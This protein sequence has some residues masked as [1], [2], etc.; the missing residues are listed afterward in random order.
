VQAKRAIEETCL[1]V[2][3]AASQQTWQR[4][5]ILTASKS[6][7]QCPQ[8][9]PAVNIHR[10]FPH[11]A[12]KNQQ[13]QTSMT[14]PNTSVDD[15]KRYVDLS[16][17]ELVFLSGGETISISLMSVIVGVTAKYRHAVIQKRVRS[18]GIEIMHIAVPHGNTYKVVA[19]Y[20]AQ[21]CLLVAGTQ[22]LLKATREFVDKHNKAKEIQTT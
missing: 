12:T 9:L 1:L 7:N 10:S 21:R 15:R 17:S 18:N 3:R 6:Q 8:S 22:S 2:C 20:D 16:F 11:Q 14:T 19:V 13:T 4:Q 5:T